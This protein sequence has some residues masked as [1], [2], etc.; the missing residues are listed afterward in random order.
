MNDPYPIRTIGEDEFHR[1]AR[2]VANTYGVDKS[3]ATLESKRSAV[4]IDRT[5]AAYDGAEPVGGA[6]IC[7][8]VMTVPGGAA[9]PI[10]GV[11]WV[12]VSPT[13]RRRGILT[14]MMRR[15]LTGLHESG[16]EPVAVLNAAEATIY[17][18]YGYGAASRSALFL[19]HK[20]DMALRPGVD[21]GDGH[22]R[23]LPEDEARPLMEKVYDTARRE[24]VGWLDR[25]PRFWDY[26]LRDRDGEST[27]AT[28][29]RRAVHLTADGEAT[30]Y[31]LFR[32]RPGE[33]DNPDSP[34]T[35]RVEELI[36]TTRQAYAALWRFLIGIDLHSLVSYEGALDDTLPH[37]LLDPRA[38]RVSLADRLWTRLVDVDR[39]LTARGYATPLDVVLDV[40]DG[41]CP[42]NAGRWR[43]RAEGG[44]VTCERT[45]GPAGLRL[46]STELGAAYLGGTTL[47]S[48]GAAGLVEELRPGA[49]E[50][51]SAAFRTRREP[52]NPTGGRFPSF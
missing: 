3:D 1:W 31:V 29:M 18:R 5:I 44:A 6:S 12:G 17:G 11:A 43:L 19:G 39:A 49:L 15:Q 27:G 23:F 26:R 40:E 34:G 52:F 22:I 41:F 48:M 36:T 13:H 33:R 7:T 51:C 28:T 2:T 8:R 21:T 14:S 45:G 10:A 50:A 16:G 9:L 35:V 4:E 47:A 20:R 32:L 30:G 37:L 42:W 38:A 25:P 46:S 24:S